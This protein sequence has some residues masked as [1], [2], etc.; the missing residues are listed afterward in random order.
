MTT[1]HGIGAPTG[2]RLTIDLGALA[3]NWRLLAATAPASETAAALKADAYGIGME[4]AARALVKAGC[5]T[6]FV[7]LPSEGV[8]LRVVAPDAAIHILNGFTPGSAVVFSR[9]RLT[10]VLGSPGEVD[11]WLSECGRDCPAPT[12]HVDTGM[13]RL[14]LSMQEA[15]ELAGDHVRLAALGPGLVM[16]HLACADEP[17]HPLNRIQ[18]QRFA[19]VRAM[20]PGVAGSLANSAGIAMPEARHDLNRPGISIYGGRARARGDHAVRPVVRLD[21]RVIR[22]REAA[23]GESVGYGATVVLARPSLIAIVSTGY[24]DGYPRRIGMA[25]GEAA[26]GGRRVPLIGRVSMDVLAVDVTELGPGA[27]RAG[28]DVELIGPSIP[29]AEI[30]D[31]AGTIDYEILTGLGRRFA[32]HYVE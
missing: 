26:I 22:V 11:D 23:A 4:A 29:L 28:D 21:A 27:V 7:A 13:N 15:A 8:A 10:P 32:R 12:I 24:A 17:D 1:P 9:Y 2:A 30:A 6:F 25:G 19:A 31:A 16:S 20:Y 18:V 3:D 5:R 14:G